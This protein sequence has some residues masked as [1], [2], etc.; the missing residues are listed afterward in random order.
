MYPLAKEAAK[1]R[2]S[3]IMEHFEPIMQDDEEGSSDFEGLATSKNDFEKE[4]K[5]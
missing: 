1:N 3:L 4:N 5:K 2:P